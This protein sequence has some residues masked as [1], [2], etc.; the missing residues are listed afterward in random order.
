M[1]QD[2][3]ATHSHLRPAPGRVFHRLSRIGADGGLVRGMYIEFTP[4]EA[5]RMAR[6]LQEC[7]RIALAH[8]AAPPATDILPDNWL[9][10]RA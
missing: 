4:A 6:E 3:E 7:A 1:D 8:D 2:A 9:T 10:E 5:L